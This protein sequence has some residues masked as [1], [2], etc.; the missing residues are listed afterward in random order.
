HALNALSDSIEHIIA[1]E[2]YHLLEH[3][4]PGEKL[5]LDERALLYMEP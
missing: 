3:R 2:S 5:Q 4:Y 1:A